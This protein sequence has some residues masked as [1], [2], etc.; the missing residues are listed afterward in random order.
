MESQWWFEACGGYQRVSVV[1]E[2]EEDRDYVEAR[3]AMV[4]AVGRNKTMGQGLA[5]E[6]ERGD[7]G[8]RE[9]QSIAI[10]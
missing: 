6:A 10:F 9:L 2:G 3:A 7:P 5:R 8:P 1:S 4:Q